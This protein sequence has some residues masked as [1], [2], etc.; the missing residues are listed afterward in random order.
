M[1]SLIS[2]FSPLTFSFLV[3]K[4]VEELQK[5]KADLWFHVGKHSKATDVAAAPEFEQAP[6]GITFDRFI[7]AC[8]VVTRARRAFFNVCPSVKLLEVCIK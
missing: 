6:L 1:V 4:G 3:K 8:V 2:Q 7:R 5:N